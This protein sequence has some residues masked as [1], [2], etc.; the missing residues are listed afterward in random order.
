MC[1]VKHFSTGPLLLRINLFF[2]IMIGKF[3]F[4]YFNIK[5]TIN[6][7]RFMTKML[8]YQIYL[9]KYQLNL[10]SF[11]FPISI[12]QKL[13]VL[14]FSQTLSLSFCEFIYPFVW[15]SKSFHSQ[16]DSHI[17]FFI[18]FRSNNL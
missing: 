13:T 2:P 8:I 10:V 12:L 6:S 7:F 14:G 16:L 15:K 17:F 4:P 9:A 5:L 11:Y 18:L 3:L 1:K